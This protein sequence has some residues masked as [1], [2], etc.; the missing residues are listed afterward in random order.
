MEASPSP[1]YGAALL[2]RFGFI[3]IPGSN[4]G[5]SARRTAR[6]VPPG[7]LFRAHRRDLCV[8]A[9]RPGVT[10][11]VMMSDIRL[12]SEA[13]ARTRAHPP[14]QRT[15][16][17]LP[18]DRSHPPYPP[19]ADMPERPNSAGSEHNHPHTRARRA[20]HPASQDL[21]PATTPRPPSPVRLRIPH[22]TNPIAHQMPCSHHHRTMDFTPSGGPCIVDL[23]QADQ[24]LV[25]QRIE[26]L[27]T[28][29]K[30]AGSNP[31]ER[32]ADERPSPGNRR[33]S[34]S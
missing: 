28:D 19:S 22:Q 5:A 32:T 1:V 3:P 24:A 17:R 26:H 18:L 11:R 13:L 34:F 14:S 30:V 6:L 27:T 8:I 4:P 10:T 20:A 15:P 7:G 21:P 23:G 2:M 25:A 12:I 29:Q 33:G 9:W 31:A 16:P